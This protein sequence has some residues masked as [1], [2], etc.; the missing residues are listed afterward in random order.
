[1]AESGRRRAA[2]DSV[3]RARDIN[4]AQAST[5]LDAAYAEGPLGAVSNSPSMAIRARSAR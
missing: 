5:V 1:M 2:V 4:R 3:L